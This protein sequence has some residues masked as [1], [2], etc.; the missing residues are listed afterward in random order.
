MQIRRQL[1]QTSIDW[2]HQIERKQNLKK[3]TV[4]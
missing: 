3:R 2:A 4:N 1:F